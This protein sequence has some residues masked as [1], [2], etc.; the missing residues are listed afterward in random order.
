MVGLLI[1]CVMEEGTIC[2]G[3][4]ATTLVVKNEPSMICFVLSKIR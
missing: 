2:L 4:Y 1:V 3:I